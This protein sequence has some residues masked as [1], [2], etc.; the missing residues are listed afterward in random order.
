MR[1]LAAGGPERED[2]SGER[3]RSAPEGHFGGLSGTP[4]LCSV[5]KADGTTT[6]V[7]HLTDNRVAG[8]VFTVSYTSA[9]FS[10]KNVGTAKTVT[11]TGFTLTGT[12]AADYSLSPTTLTTTANITARSLTVTATGSSKI[13]DGTTAATVSLADNRVTG[14]LFTDNYAAA[15][16]VQADA[17]T[18]IAVNVS[19]ISISG[20]DAEP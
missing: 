2:I 8:D 16:F 20:T 11:G 12:A 7:V 19:G 10:D 13:Y 3:G 18:G 1:Q 6:A 4:F 15:T 14:D 5:E 17:G 9:S